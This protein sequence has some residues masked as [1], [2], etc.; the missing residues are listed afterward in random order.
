M[1][2]PTLREAF[3][4]ACEREHFARLAWHHYTGNRYTP[5]GQA[6][7]TALLDAENA[8]DAARKAW[9]LAEAKERVTS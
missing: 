2:A 1:T 5:D 3:R 8:A 7:L 6:I 4:D 9:E